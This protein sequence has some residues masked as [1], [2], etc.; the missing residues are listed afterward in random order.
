LYTQIVIVISLPTHI[1]SFD[2]KHYSSPTK[3]IYFFYQFKKKAY[4]IFFLPTDN[5]LNR[6]YYL[7]FDK[8]SIISFFFFFLST[9]IRF[10]VECS[11][12]YPPFTYFME[13]PPPDDFISAESGQSEISLLRSRELSCVVVW[14]GKLFRENNPLMFTPYHR[15]VACTHHTDQTFYDLNEFERYIYLLI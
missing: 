3:R 7:P 13:L 15:Q 1:R 11:E 14:V 8:L 6:Y 12:Y 2:R 4:N 9:R 10:S 5:F